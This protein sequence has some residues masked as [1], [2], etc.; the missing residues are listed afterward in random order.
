LYRF[1]WAADGT[2]TWETYDR[3][4][5]D[6]DT[7]VNTNDDNNNGT[8]DE[9]VW[10]QDF[11][12]KGTYS[13][14]AATSRLTI[15]WKGNKWAMKTAGSGWGWTGDWGST[16]N[17]AT[18]A[19]GDFTNDA[20]SDMTGASLTG[21]VSMTKTQGLDFS[22]T[23][24]VSSGTDI[25]G[26]MDDIYDTGMFFHG[27]TYF[28]ESEAYVSNTGTLESIKTTKSQ[29]QYMLEISATSTTWTDETYS[30]DTA[31]T[32]TPGAGSKGIYI[33]DYVKR[34]DSNSYFV[35]DSERTDTSFN[36]LSAGEDITAVN[37]NKYVLHLFAETQDATGTVSGTSFTYSLVTGGGEGGVWLTLANYF[38]VN[39]SETKLVGTPTTIG[40]AVAFMRTASGIYLY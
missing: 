30:I 31:G 18:Y 15:G 6:Y 17:G 20:I 36:D 7:T 5:D 4:S 32:V 25:G 28:E 26:V 2:W 40:N 11:G 29:Q 21:C 1:T 14:D 12:Y 35:G 10:Y 37:G 33:W 24:L 22:D 3:E 34:E 38:N 13:Y 16:F 8:Y 19:I 27:G 39:Y 9:G 23:E